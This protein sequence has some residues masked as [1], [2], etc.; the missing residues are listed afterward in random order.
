M[1]INVNSGDGNSIFEIAH[2]YQK[3]Q[4]RELMKNPEEIRQRIKDGSDTGSSK[5][6]EEF[7][8]VNN[9]LFQLK[10]KTNFKIED[11]SEKRKAMMRQLSSDSNIDSDKLYADFINLDRVLTIKVGKDIRALNK[12]AF[13]AIT[14]E[15]KILY[16]AVFITALRDRKT[17]F[18]YQDDLIREFEPFVTAFDKSLLSPE[19]VSGESYNRLASVNDS[20]PNLLGQVLSLCIKLK[21]QL[22]P[23]YMDWEKEIDQPKMTDLV[24]QAKT[25][26]ITY[27]KLSEMK[28]IVDYNP[29]YIKIEKPLGAIVELIFRMASGVGITGSSD[30]MRYEEL[31]KVKKITP[32]IQAQIKDNIENKLDAIDPAVVYSFRPSQ[33]D[34]IKFITESKQIIQDAYKNYIDDANIIQNYIEDV[35]EQA[36]GDLYGELGDVIL[37]IEKRTEDKNK[38]TGSGKTTNTKTNRRKQLDLFVNTFHMKRFL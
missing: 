16:I 8:K 15:N 33:N 11:V 37:E 22:T 20:I 34:I 25:T 21:S 23:K 29:I 27:I 4:I 12:T 9:L 10:T 32:E 31:K 24:E 19:G 7:D 2:Q 28:A 18:P 14:Q 13:P 36:Y 1:N 35:L 26:Q 38:L 30:E 6:I 3:M 5:F 17:K